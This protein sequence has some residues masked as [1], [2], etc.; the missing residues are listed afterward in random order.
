[1]WSIHNPEDCEME[2][3]VKI[4]RQD[5]NPNNMAEKDKEKSSQAP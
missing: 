2:K 1:M 3:Q 5:L 4:R